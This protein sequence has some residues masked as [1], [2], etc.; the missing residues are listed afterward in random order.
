MNIGSRIRDIRML[1]NLTITALAEAVGTTRPYLRGVKTPSFD[2]LEKICQA[3]NITIDDLFNKGTE[4]SPLTP[5]LKDLVDGAKSL[6]PEQLEK[7]NEFIK[8]LK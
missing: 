1:K 2:M 6:T 4:P 3:L 7:L 5:G 8:T